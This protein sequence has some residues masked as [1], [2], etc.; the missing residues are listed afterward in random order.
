MKMKRILCMILALAMLGSISALA[1][2]HPFEDVAADS[3]YN[4]DVQ[5]VY[6]KGLMSGTAAN[7]FA[8]NVD[9]TRAMLVTVLYR[10]E[11]SPEVK[12]TGPFVDVPR[13]SYYCDPV[14]WAYENEIV[15][16]VTVSLFAPDNK[17]SREQ[18]VTI[19]ARYANY[20]GL[21][22][23]AL[24]DLTSFADR[25]DV[26]EYA[27]NSFRW[28]VGAGIINGLSADT[29]G[30]QGTATRAQCAAILH[31]FID[32]QSKNVEEDWELPNV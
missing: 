15:K 24:D 22:T 10:L 18:M 3:W 28:A 17:I 21:E 19:F 25:R 9:M 11:G 1:V 13:D 8:P 5:Y 29:L 2:S 20:K 7:L 23:L 14:A 32:W 30:P 16:G 6:D 12:G 26:A 27:L 31:R 4:G